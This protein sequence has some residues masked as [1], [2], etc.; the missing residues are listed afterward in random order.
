[1]IVREWSDKFW[2]VSVGQIQ[3]VKLKVLTV[4]YVTHVCL[5]KNVLVTYVD[6]QRPKM[7]DKLS[8]LFL[9]KM[10]YGCS[11]NDLLFFLPPIPQILISPWQ[12]AGPRPSKT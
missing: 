6:P 3:N 9:S 2:T 8:G 12:Q 5:H 4:D 7:S 10:I 11:T 1:M